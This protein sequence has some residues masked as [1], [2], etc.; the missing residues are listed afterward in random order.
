MRGGQFQ[1]K[2]NFRGLELDAQYGVTDRG[3]A[4]AISFAATVGGTFDDD[5]GR[6]VASLTY[7]P[8]RGGTFPRVATP[9]RAF[10]HRQRRTG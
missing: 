9:L 1:L 7:F 6:A 3:D 8:D 4:E 10:R 5:R 2:R